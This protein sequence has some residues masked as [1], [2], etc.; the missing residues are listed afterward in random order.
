MFE[1]MTALVIDDA[2]SIRKYIAKLLQS[3]LGFSG[4]I[5]ESSASGALS[6]LESHGM[7]DLI[8]CDWEMPL[9]S[10]FALL[11]QL[12]HH[13]TWKKI[14]FVM[15]TTRKDKESIVMAIEAGVAEYLIKPF[16]AQTLEAKLGTIFNP[17]ESQKSER[18]VIT[19]NSD[20]Q[21]NFKGRRYIGSFV[22]ISMGGCRIKTS[23]FKDGGNIFDTVQL[24]IQFAEQKLLLSA[25]LIS[26]EGQINGVDVNAT[27][28]FDS[29][30]HSSKL[31]LKKF[32][33]TIR[34]DVQNEESWQ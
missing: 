6:A 34:I 25:K 15:A 23:V 13:H 8:I 33:D 11:T 10:G 2:G 18:L 9:I 30:E 12:K 17:V 32:L 5:Q 29:L 7:V 4:V 26:L 16:D 24:S 1:S 27:F 21:I 3:Q 19:Y 14:P 22:D 20:V 31:D 28:V